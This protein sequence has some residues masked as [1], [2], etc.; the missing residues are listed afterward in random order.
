MTKELESARKRLEK[1]RR[2]IT[3]HARQYYVLDQPEI[4]DAEYDK[5]FQKLLELEEKY[6]ELITDDSP[7]LRVGAPPLEKFESVQHVYPMLSLENA[8]SDADLDGFEERL[9]RFLN[10]QAPISYVAEPKLDGLAVELVYENGVF[11]L[12]ST[13]GDGRTGENI[14]VNLR[15]V[16]AIPLKLFGT[17]LPKRL[18]VRGEVFMSLEGFKR[19]N[20]ER[21]NAAEALF[22]NPRNAAAGSLRQLDSKLTARRPLDFYAYGV[23]DPSMVSCS[24]QRE[25]FKLLNEYG[26]KINPLVRLCPTME[27]VKEHYRHLLEIRSRLD[28]DIDGMVVKV[29]S[30]ALQGRLGNKARSPR[31]AIACKF[32]ASQGTTRL[33]D[34]D[35]QVGRTGVITPVALLEPV[36]IGGVTVSRATLHNEDEIKRKGIR[37]GDMVLVQRAGDVIPEIVQPVLAKRNGNEQLIKMPRHCPSCSHDLIREPGEA[38]LRCV[39]PHCPAQRLQSLIHFAGKSGID[40]EGLGKKA[41]EQLFTE[42]IIED[43]PDIYTL[44]ADKLENLDGWAQ[45]SAENVVRAIAD[46]K[47]ISLGRFLAALGIRYVGEVTAHLLEQRFHSLDRLLE[48]SKEEL[49]EVESIGAQMANSIVDYFSDPSVRT[50]LQRLMD[51][52]VSPQRQDTASNEKQPLEN[53][54]FLFTGGLSSLSRSEAK[55]IIKKMGGQVSSSLSKKVTHLV[56]GDKPGSKL[57]KAKDLGISI[58]DEKGFQGL[59]SKN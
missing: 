41:M 35:F 4:A 37:L 32:P 47:E 13:R 17:D 18:E 22:A 40:I 5:L 31:W 30:F 14:T 3:Y 52:G 53:M 26:F 48:I 20:A 38:A 7:S 10:D 25:L 55:E 57:Q 24:S 12:G 19:L 42:K 6:P 2:E 9:Q 51:L 1:L 11:T 59:I 8:F 16:A 21:G 49:L 34:V 43:I 23:S 27:E 58:L 44:T 29:D 28:Y 15:T 50:M 36:L 54:V 46:R 39:N 56:C 33:A 45:K